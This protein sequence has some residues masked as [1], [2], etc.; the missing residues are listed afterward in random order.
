[1]DSVVDVVDVSTATLPPQADR[2]RRAAIRGR[3]TTTQ[4]G[5]K[6]PSAES[7]ALRRKLLIGLAAG[8]AAGF[9]SGLF[10]IGGGLIVVPVLVLLL[11]V[12]QKIASATSVTSIVVSASAAAVPF[13]AQGE[14]EFGAAGAMFTGAALGALAGVRLIDRLSSRVV[15]TLFVVVAGVAAVR[16]F[17]TASSGTGADFTLGL[18]S[19]VALIGVGLLAGM[20]AALLGIG[21]GVVYVPALALLFGAPQH[22]AQGTSLVTIVPTALVATAAHTRAGRVDWPLAAAISLGGLFSGTL[23][24]ILALNTAP[25]LLRRL[26][27][28]FLVLVAVRM[29]RQMIRPRR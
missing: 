24:G 18:G 2:R 12:D 9:G 19:F 29:L 17:L 21:G 15:G 26:F 7:P 6:M 13:I 28:V 5:E 27:A 11:H 20:L 8:M 14:V 10:G 22:L 4:Y 1:M 16:L 23:S 3:N 25:D